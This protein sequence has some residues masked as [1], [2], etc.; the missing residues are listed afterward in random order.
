[1]ALSF[2]DYS[3]NFHILQDM[4]ENS[5]SDRYTCYHVFIH[6]FDMYHTQLMYYYKT[7]NQLFRKNPVGSL[8]INNFGIIDQHFWLI[9][10]LI[11]LTSKWAI[12]LL[13][14]KKTSLFNTVH[15]ELL[16][17]RQAL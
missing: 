14:L 12:H 10:E 5:I 11:D 1:M 13:F 16:T 15:K 3:S 6:S 4:I 7:H 2:L 17:T 8:Y 9:P